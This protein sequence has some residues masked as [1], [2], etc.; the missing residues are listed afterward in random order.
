MSSSDSERVGDRFLGYEGAS[1]SDSMNHI[2]TLD[3][4]QMKLFQRPVRRL[5]VAFGCLRD[6]YNKQPTQQDL[7]AE[8]EA[9]RWLS[10]ITLAYSGIEQAMK[11]LLQLREIKFPR[12]AR[13]HLIGKLFKKLAPQEQEVLRYSYAIYRSL[14]DYIPQET[15]DDFLEAIGDGY[16]PWRYFLSEDQTPPQ[17]HPGAMLEI[18]SALTDILDAKMTSKLV[19]NT[20]NWR[21]EECLKDLFANT[22][23]DQLC[24]IDQ[25]QI[26]KLKAQLNEGIAT[27]YCA[28]FLYR[29]AQGQPLSSDDQLSYSP[30][31]A[32]LVDKIK[33]Y[34]ANHVFTE[35]VWRARNNKL[36]WN[37]RLCRFEMD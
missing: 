24:D 16:M 22:L 34:T 15:A 19:L 32:T 6:S 14:Y 35:Y 4:C 21:I 3:A 13:G 20:V 18:W 26:D 28:E 37:P 29:D 25:S 10:T 9:I 1:M 11:C 36:A 30:V 7:E 5:W 12:G 23:G 8:Y 17:T 31:L 27:N 33:R 2:T